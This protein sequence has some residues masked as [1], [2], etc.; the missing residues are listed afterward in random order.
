MSIKKNFTVAGRLGQGSFGSVFKVVRK[1]DA[2][3]YAMK[4][5][6]I[7][8]M[9]REEVRD[10]VNE[11]RVLASVRHAHV[12]GFMEAFLEK[13][14][15]QLCIVM[16]FCGRGDLA[17]V[18]EAAKKARRPLAEPRIWTTL[19][20]LMSGVAALHEKGIV[21]RDL[22]PANCFITAAGAVKIGDMN[23][24]KLTKDG[25]LMRTRIGTPF[26]MSPQQWWSM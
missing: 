8:R 16:E 19:I 15:E 1:S 18:I 12:V 17:S 5:V 24:S 26:Y 20:Q 9:R 4:V 11:I 6:D 10:A 13:N 22:K 23:V 14:N 7:S 25:A 21:H 2:T 3:D